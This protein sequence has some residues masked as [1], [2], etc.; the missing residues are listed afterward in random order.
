MS[1]GGDIGSGFIQP[2]DKPFPYV[3]Y[4]WEKNIPGVC[5]E[6]E[7]MYINSW[8]FAEVVCHEKVIYKECSDGLG[9]SM[10]KIF[11]NWGFDGKVIV[12]QSASEA[13]SDG[14]VDKAGR[15]LDASLS[16]CNYT[17]ISAQ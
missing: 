2:M 9:L 17:A 10:Y 6:D 16:E 13:M 12:K 15:W 3:G 5:L 7:I 8:S 4:G 11:K 14:E 1:I